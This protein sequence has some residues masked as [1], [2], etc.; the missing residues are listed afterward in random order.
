MY[1]FLMIAATVLAAAVPGPA[2]WAA[3]GLEVVHRSE[4][5]FQ[6]LNPARGDASPKAGA[7]WGDLGADVASGAIIEFAAGF[8]SPPHIHNITYRAVVIS[9]AVHN[10]DPAARALW[11]GPGSFWTQPAGESHV[12][13]A[14]GDQK[15]VAFLEIQEGPYLVAA[16]EEAFDAGE[17]PLNLDAGNVVWLDAA[18]IDWVR[19]GSGVMDAAQIAFLWGS[20]GNGGRHGSFLKL[21]AGARGELQGNGAWMRT[22][23]IQGH[24]RHGASDDAGMVDL[25]PGSYF[26]SKGSRRHPISCETDEACLLYVS[27]AGRYTFDAADAPASAAANATP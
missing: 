11:L 23:V 7:L 24:L 12:T 13:A 27:T 3:D 1:R 15:G 6:P 9:G 2:S 26:G 25:E 19:H 14:A 18:D 22:V 17:R 8:S 5:R 16:P 10:D 20:P 4:V 21:P